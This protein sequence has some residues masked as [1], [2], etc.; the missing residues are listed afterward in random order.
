MDRADH[1]NHRKPF[2]VRVLTVWDVV[3]GGR[4]RLSRDPEISARSS[5]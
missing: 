3:K 5:S 2:T 1:S 4:S